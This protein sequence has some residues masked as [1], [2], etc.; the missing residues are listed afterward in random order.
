MA[1]LR[2]RPG[3]PAQIGQTPDHGLGSGRAVGKMPHLF[4]V[5]PSHHADSA[6]A[7]QPR[8]QRPR[9]AGPAR[10]LTHGAGRSRRSILLAGRGRYKDPTLRDRRKRCRH[11]ACHANAG[12]ASPRVRRR[13]AQP[14]Q[15]VHEGHRW[16]NERSVCDRSCGALRFVVLSCSCLSRAVPVRVEGKNY[17]I[18]KLIAIVHSSTR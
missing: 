16:P 1:S 13:V 7:A 18:L 3:V 6:P 2:V 15:H 11:V 14:G 5:G 10:P 17:H 4:G 12:L 9:G 8:R